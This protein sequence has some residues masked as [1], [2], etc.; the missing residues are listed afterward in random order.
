MISP[1]NRTTNDLPFDV[2][3]TVDHYRKLL[4]L[5]TAHWQN[6]PYDA[7]PWGA[8]FILWRHDLDYS[9]N[10]ALVLAR[11]EREEGIRATYFLNPHSEFYNVAE[12]AQFRIIK[13]IL[14]LGHSLG[15]HFDGAFH[16]IADEAALDH[17]VTREAS[18]LADLFGVRPVAFSFHNPV[19][20]HL[21]CEGDRYGGL[22]NCYSRRFKTEVPYCSDSNGYW[23]FR[24]LYDVL[25]DGSDPCLQVLTHPGW[26]QETP[27]PPRRR[28]FRCAFG[29]ARSMMRCY[30]QLLLEHGR[31]NHRGSAACLQ[32]L[33][34][35]LPRA[36]ELCDFLWSEGHFSTLFLELWRL[37]E[38][39]VTSVCIT[40]LQKEWRLPAA[41]VSAFMG[42]ESLGVDGFR[43]FQ[44]LFDETWQAT[45]GLDSARFSE[46]VGVRDQ[47]VHGRRAFDG[48][49]L[50]QGCVAVCEAIRHLSA[51]GLERPIACDGLEH[52]ESIYRPTGDTADAAVSDGLEEVAGEMP[53]FPKGRWEKLKA[54][55]GSVTATL[56]GDN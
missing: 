19:A 52:V 38:K 10:R 11:V 14:S 21:A 31:I 53:A 54:S 40:V 56:P 51:W 20:E 33:A 36:F 6:V 39:Q 50:E 22:V 32:I 30:D 46:W 1:D 16:G 34:R 2:D 42:Q 25:S 29:R 26:W 43:L 15:L 44:A 23:R 35:S 55:L 18:Y 24:R 41:E 48:A 7:I 3:F 8:K 9:V 12:L 17:L 49:Y 5:A 47:L 45:G 37:H 13:E 28:I 4:R 27:M